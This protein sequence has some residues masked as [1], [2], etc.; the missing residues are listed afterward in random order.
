M[1]VIVL[2]KGTRSALRSAFGCSESA[3]SMML[4]F[5]WNSLIARRMRSFAVNNMNA[6][7]ILD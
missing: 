5:K 2:R 1:S 4:H 3:I 6:F 7:P